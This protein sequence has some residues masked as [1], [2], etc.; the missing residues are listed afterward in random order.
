VSRSF[1]RA[2]AGDA[3]D[4]TARSEC[5]QSAFLPSAPTGLAAPP[6]G[7]PAPL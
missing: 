5:A 4:L 1:S 3:S 7:A 2:S 6:C